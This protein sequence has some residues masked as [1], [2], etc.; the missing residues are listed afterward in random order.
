MVGSDDSEL[1]HVCCRYEWNFFVNIINKDRPYTQQDIN[2][3]V[4]RQFL[5][6]REMSTEYI[7]SMESHTDMLTQFV[8]ARDTCEPLR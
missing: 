6:L 1:L 8:S 2:V 7:L 5:K 3:I 4:V